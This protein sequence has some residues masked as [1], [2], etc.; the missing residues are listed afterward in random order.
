MG[1]APAPPGQSGRNGHDAELAPLAVDMARRCYEDSR[2]SAE[3]DPVFREHW[4]EG[5]K[6]SARCP[7]RLCT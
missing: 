7:L 4:E 6:E 2:A 5:G 3:L 1:R